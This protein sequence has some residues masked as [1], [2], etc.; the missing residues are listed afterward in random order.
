MSTTF[1]SE[2]IE[3][4]DSQN[5][6]NI[7]KKKSNIKSFNFFNLGNNKLNKSKHK[8][9]NMK[10]VKFN[11]DIA[12]IDVESWKKYNVELT[13]GEYQEDFD[14]ENDANKKEKGQKDK[15]IKKNKKEHISC[16]CLII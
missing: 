2:T 1:E 7:I 3:G 5:T 11:K 15:N 4:R 16:I 6:A 13:S 10:K 14:G 9:I 12:I 8:N